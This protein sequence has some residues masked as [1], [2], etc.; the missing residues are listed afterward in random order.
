MNLYL[1]TNVYSEL[2]RAA[3]ADAEAQM[4]QDE[5]AWLREGL[6]A[7]KIT[8]HPSL[9]V[10]DELVAQMGTDREAV[11]RKLRMM[12][13]LVGFHGM[14]K[15]PADII[16]EAFAAYA[17]GKAPP[18]IVL[19]E[20]RRRKVVGP[21]CE[22]CSGSTQ[23]DRELI[24]IASD[25]KDS[26]AK[27]SA[28][29]A[30]AGKKSAEKLAW[31]TKTPEERAAVTL[32]AWWDLSAEDWAGSI[33]DH[34]G[35]GPG[36]RQQGLSGLISLPPV[37]QFLGVAFS[38]IHLEAVKA[39]TR[40]PHRNDGYDLWHACTGS[41]ADAFVTFDRRL[42]DHLDAVKAA[43]GAGSQVFRSVR[44]LREHLG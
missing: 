38:Q 34:L 44:A 27:W 7:R 3:Q 40:A 16:P 14:L 25:V 37:R 36:C 1:D 35:V 28:S 5:A 23:H 19:S 21:L 42:A 6:S 11:V 33:A 41:T 13:A 26:K 15:Q 20:E 18:S 39:P 8:T 29:R 9:P 24:E 43:T 30:E 17:E 22:V 4:S 32:K 12:R 31:A 10:L 2:D